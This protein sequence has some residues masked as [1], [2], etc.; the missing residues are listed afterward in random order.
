V[1]QV[2][3]LPGPLLLRKSQQKLEFPLQVTIPLQLPLQSWRESGEE[4]MN[5]EGSVYRR[6]DGLWVGQYK[7][8]T[9]YRTDEEDDQ[10]RATSGRAGV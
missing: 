2:R 10:M 5:G 6:K 9:P 4:D 8:Q 7:V 1:S 3:I